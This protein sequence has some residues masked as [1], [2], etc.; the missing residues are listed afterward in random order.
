[1]NAERWAPLAALLLLAAALPAPALA[2][3]LEDQ[4]QEAGARAERLARGAAEDPE[5]AAANA[6]GP[7]WQGEQA[8]WSK[9]WTCSTAYAADERAGEAAGGA[10]GCQAPRDVRAGEEQAAE[11]SSRAE[12]SEAD[13]ERAARD[14]IAAAQAF[15]EATRQHP[16]QAPSH[17]VVFLDRAQGIAERLVDVVGELLTL[18]ADGLRLAGEGLARAGQGLADG[19][20]AG[21][22]A[23]LGAGQAAAAGA[24]AGVQAGLAPIEAGWTRLSEAVGLDEAGDAPA[25]AGEPAPV[26]AAEAEDVTEAAPIE[27]G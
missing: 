22:D 13:A 15:V 8:N 26:D 25:D 17:L 10:L 11:Q 24:G 14:A 12:P 18:P 19:T 16:E 3:S 23:L 27:V 7:G 21:V 4:A 2:Q 5:G 6:T 9:A 1:M 20:R